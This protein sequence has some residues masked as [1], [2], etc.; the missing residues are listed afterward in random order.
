MSAPACEGCH[1]PTQFDS[2]CAGVSEAKLRLQVGQPKLEV[3]G[4]ILLY[5]HPFV[6]QVLRADA[7]S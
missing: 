3:T 5:G 4:N 7:Q 6:F 2:F 1:R